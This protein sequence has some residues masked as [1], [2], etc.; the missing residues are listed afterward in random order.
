[1]CTRYGENRAPVESPQ[2]TFA[3][4]SPA[5]SNLMLIHSDILHASF[6]RLASSPIQQFPLNNADP[7]KT[8]HICRQPRRKA[9]LDKVRIPGCP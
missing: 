5:R 7:G 6:P 8:V 4:L 9:V 2:M 1:M 3:K